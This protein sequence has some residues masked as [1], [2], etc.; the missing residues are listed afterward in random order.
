[1]QRVP[2]SS[3]GGAKFVSPA[4]QRGV[5]GRD[6]PQSPVGAVLKGGQS[7]T[8]C[9]SYDC[10]GLASKPRF[11][12]APSRGK[13]SELATR[14]TACTGTAFLPHR[15]AVCTER[16][17]ARHKPGTR[18]VANVCNMVAKIIILDNIAPG[19]EHKV[20]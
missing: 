11:V 4:L 9:R 18:N 19:I 20:W 12:L 13:W 15:L 5:W 2:I 1:M 6:L 14:R 16:G 3:A 7:T 17:W 8:I 10:P